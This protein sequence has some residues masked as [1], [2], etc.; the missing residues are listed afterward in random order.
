MNTPQNDTPPEPQAVGPFNSD[1]N[2]AQSSTN[3]LSPDQDKGDTA[4][5]PEPSVCCPMC[6]KEVDY[7]EKALACTECDTW[8]HK[9]CDGMADDV[10]S[11]HVLN[12]GCEYKC[13]DCREHIIAESLLKIDREHS[14]NPAPIANDLNVK[15]YVNLPTVSTICNGGKTDTQTKQSVRPSSCPPAK[16]IQFNQTQDSKTMTSPMS[17]T[18]LDLPRL[19]DS[20]VVIPKITPHGAKQQ[21]QRP[22]APRKGENIL[23]K[24]TEKISALT[25]KLAAARIRTTNLEHQLKQQEISTSIH[26]QINPKH[27]APTQQN[28]QFTAIPQPHSFSPSPTTQ[29][30]GA[31]P[32]PT[33]ASQQYGQ[34]GQVNQNQNVPGQQIPQFT[35]IPQPHSFSHSPTPQYAGAPPP[36]TYAPQQHSQFINQHHLEMQEMRQQ[37]ELMKMENHYQLEMLKMQNQII[38]EKLNNQAFLQLGMQ[39]YHPPA[40]VMHPLFPIPFTANNPAQFFAPQPQPSML[41]FQ[42]YNRQRRNHE[43]WMAAPQLNQNANNIYHNQTHTSRTSLNPQPPNTSVKSCQENGGTKFENPEQPLPQVSGIQDMKKTVQTELIQTEETDICGMDSAI[44]SNNAGKS[45][46]INSEGVIVSESC[47]P[48]PPKASCVLPSIGSP[49]R[50]EADLFSLTESREESCDN[51]F[52]VQNPNPTFPT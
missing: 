13:G 52:L 33:Y 17:T 43:A 12:P 11:L 10:Y 34:L 2:L 5:V 29:H 47:Q 4:S 25:S 16:N 35:A 28:P 19:N 46:M 37:M 41:Q 31:P 39:Q 9:S 26:G 30:V 49:D 1:I 6:S 27:N 50:L 15:L 36:L 7:G 42:P 40:P 23:I 21:N 44:E 3:R 8:I 14:N 38:I 51:C 32:P 48:S 24:E 22:R 18:T 20:E 45:N